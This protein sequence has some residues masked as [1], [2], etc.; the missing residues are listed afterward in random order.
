MPLESQREEQIY[1]F[2]F[3]FASSRRYVRMVGQRLSPTALLLGNRPFTVCREDWRGPST[4]LD[5]YGK[6]RSHGVRIADHPA[7][8]GHCTD[9][10]VEATYLP[11]TNT[12]S[13]FSTPIRIV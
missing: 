2:A 8:T 9:S 1:R 12:I 5:G 13:N 4:G 11:C 6:S 7:P 10:T 3:A